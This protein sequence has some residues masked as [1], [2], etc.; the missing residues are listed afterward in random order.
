MDATKDQN[1]QPKP[2]KKSRKNPTPAETGAEE[3][4]EE[5]TEVVFEAPKKNHS[6]TGIIVGIVLGLVAVALVV[7][8]YV[9]SCIY[10]N[11]NKVLADASGKFFN[12]EN[13]A[14]DGSITLRNSDKDAPVREI[15]VWFD[16]ASTNLPNAS[17]VRIRTTVE[18]DGEARDIAVDAGA[19]VMKDG[20]F[21]LKISGI[22]DSLKSFGIKESDL[23][24]IYEVVELIDN[25]W[26]RVDVAELM[27]ALEI[28]K[29]DQEQINDF[30]G[31]LVSA[32]EHDTL[33]EIGSL[34]ESNN[35]LE[36]QKVEEAR[37]SDGST[38]GK[39]FEGTD[40][41]S[42]IVNYTKMAGFINGLADIDTMR[43]VYSCVR[44]LD[45]NSDFNAESFNEVSAKE[46]E[47]IFEDEAD[48]DVFFEISK[49]GHEL[50]HIV[51]KVSDDGN[52]SII[53]LSF[54]YKEATVSAPE[55]YRPATELIDELSE[56]M[57]EILNQGYD[58]EDFNIYNNQLGGEILI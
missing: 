33:K 32:T 51:A 20:V 14:L 23:G 48:V 44:D 31:C 58:T 41:Y 54:T 37:M 50:K 46:L 49:W 30:Y 47:Q 22:I 6:K 40:Y 39:S 8:A 34:Y 56:I 53:N 16:S 10:H 21:Y 24:W 4:V 19:V 26:W 12:A 13:V 11:P 18:S 42:P 43:R 2:T 36:L 45:E 28:S 25:E 29:K 35:F 7:T 57:A 38:V 17:N 1:Q 55:D 9:W 3:V 5:T 52:S 15:L 27:S